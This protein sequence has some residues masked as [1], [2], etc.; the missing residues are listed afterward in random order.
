MSSPNW[1]GQASVSIP[2]NTIVV[3]GVPVNAVPTVIGT[4]SNVTSWAN[5]NFVTYFTQSNVSPGTYM[6]GSEHFA[7]PINASNATGWGQGDYFIARICDRDANATR[8]PQM[9]FRPYT[10]GIQVN[11]ASPY[12]KGSVNRQNV[13]ILVVTSNTDIVWQAQFGKDS[14]TSYPQTRGLTCESPWFQKIA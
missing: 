5:A 6:V 7:D 13:G 4:S 10:E 14:G 3:N 1:L 11:A 8:L 2:N 12:N 9:F